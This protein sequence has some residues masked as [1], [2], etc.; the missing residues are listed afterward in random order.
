MAGIVPGMDKTS[1]NSPEKP[2]LHGG[3][4]AEIA[5][6]HGRPVADWI[7]LS[8]GI[9]PWP[10]PVPA[11]SPA[12][13]TRLPASAALAG[14]KT[15]AAGYF[16][17]PDGGLIAAAPGT[18]ALIQRLP[19]LLGRGPVTILSPTYAEHAHVWR[20]A[21]VDVAEA[22]D[23]PAPD[24]GLVVVNPNNPDGRVLPP[25]RLAS[26]AAE[27]AAGG[28]FL[29]VDEAFADVAPAVGL[30]P[31][32]PLGNVVVLR[33]FGKF[34]G[35][36]GLRLG[37][38]LAAPATVR[39]LEAALGPWAVSGPAA[40][41]GAQAMA[42][43]GWITATRARLAAAMD[44]LRG[45]LAGAGA[46]VVG[47][48]DLFVLTNW[49]DGPAVFAALAEA[50][51]YVRRFPDRAGWLRFGLPGDDGQWARLEETLARR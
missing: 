23:L 48:T 43:G 18:Q 44:R 20:G 6:A 2:V 41:I 42:D 29:V 16:G 33:S 7:D 1:P 14:L 13:W 19:G 51:I 27:A 31:H 40:E 50:G 4:L 46:S 37:F 10:Y 28:H 5:A 9:N 30:A 39:R 3:D 36:A 25:E 22:V 38:A 35:L 34:F 47:G 15:A 12:A 11:I 8:T 49:P 26:W 24:R 17:L 45:L 21:G 32:L